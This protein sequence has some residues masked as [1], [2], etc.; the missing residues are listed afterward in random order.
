MIFGIELVLLSEEISF[1]NFGWEALSVVKQI[2]Q[3]L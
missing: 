1:G 3:R 2:I